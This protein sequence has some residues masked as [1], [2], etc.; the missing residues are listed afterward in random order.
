MS[1]QTPPKVKVRTRF[2]TSPLPLN[3][4]RSPIHTERLVIRPFALNDLDGIH[5]IRR[6]PEVMIYTSVGRIDANKAETQLFMS[7]FLPPKDAETYNTVICLASTG[8]II[9]TGG[10]HQQNPTFGCPEIGYMFKKEYWG[11]GYAT[12]FLRGFLDQY[13]TLPRSGLETE[14]DAAMVDGPGEVPEMLAA[15]V[16]SHNI[17]SKRVLEKAGF[18]EFK[19]W[20]EQDSREGYSKEADLIAFVLSTTAT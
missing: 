18:R 20:T 6:Q 5:A 7:R 10:M 4:E 3:S 19:R 2:P 9:G 14:V 1:H 12:E 13:W 8:E 11:Q 17:G 15:M 16:E